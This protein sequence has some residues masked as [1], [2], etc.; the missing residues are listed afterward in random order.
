MKTAK[1]NSLK[2]I[3]EMLFKQLDRLD[4]DGMSAERLSLEVARA[5]SMAGTSKV[6]LNTIQTQMNVNKLKEKGVEILKEVGFD[7]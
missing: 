1:S 5:N 4:M 7:E 2:T 6:I 3:N